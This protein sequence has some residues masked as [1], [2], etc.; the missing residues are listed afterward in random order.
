[1]QNI[2]DDL[3]YQFFMS[4]VTDKMFS[5]EVYD[6]RAPKQKCL[7]SGVLPLL[8]TQIEQFPCEK[9]LL[10]FDSASIIVSPRSFTNL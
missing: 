10:V 3:L 8:A 4:F 7:A 6:T 9:V 1:M 5:Y 2:T